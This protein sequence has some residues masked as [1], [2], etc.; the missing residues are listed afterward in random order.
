M[1]LLENR[2]VSQRLNR[3][4]LI[5][6]I[7]FFVCAIVGIVSVSF[8]AKDF[9]TF[10]Q[11]DYSGTTYREDYAISNQRM[12]CDLGR[13]ILAANSNNKTGMETYYLNGIRYQKDAATSLENLRKLG[14]V[15]D[16]DTVSA[17]AQKQ[18]KIKAMM[19]QMHALCVEGK[20]AE[21]WKVYEE[22]YSPLLDEMRA[23]MDKYLASANKS[24]AE[25]VEKTNL[26][27]NT[28]Y[29][30][31]ICIAI[32]MVILLVVL[33]KKTVKFVTRP[34]QQLENSVAAMSEGRLDVVPTYDGQDEFG[35]L[36][37]NFRETNGS[38]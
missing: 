4:A 11:V 17:A 31:N 6:G 12:A 21:S 33:S 35:S 2:T 7:C 37:K 32:I 25:H 20:A 5:F 19:A 24:A 26:L 13:M 23:E 15:I 30:V 28:M 27:K 14:N 8:M 18:E 34:L 29:A 38:V 9:N 10:N 3:S 36:C 22:N 1:S 16:Q